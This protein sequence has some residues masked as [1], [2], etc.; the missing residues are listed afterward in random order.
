[1]KRLNKGR[2][3]TKIVGLHEAYFEIRGSKGH[4]SYVAGVD[5]EAGDIDSMY[6]L[7]L[8]RH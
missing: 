5:E 3:E 2:R 1:M 4:T 6:N 8:Q 7:V